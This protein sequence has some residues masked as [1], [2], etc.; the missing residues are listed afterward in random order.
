MD[1]RKFLKQYSLG[2][3]GGFFIPLFE[4]SFFQRGALSEEVNYKGKVLI[5]GAGVAGLYAGYILKSKGIDF[6]I[7]E[8][9]PQYGGRLAKLTGFANFPVDL[10]AQ[11]LHGKNNLIG[12]LIR[13][14]KTKVTL[15]QGKATYW[16]NNQLV[17][18]LP[19][20]IDIFEG[21]NLPDISFAEHALQEGLGDEYRY[22]VENIA[23]D[24]GA[25]SSR[26]SV[27]HTNFEFENWTSGEK[28]FRFQETFFDLIEKQIAY[29]IKDR[30]KHNTVVTQIDYTHKDILVLDADNN[31]YSAQKVIVTVPINILKSKDI[32]FTP[33]L[34]SE[35]TVAFSKIGMDAGMK[36]FFRF[37]HK[38]YDK[39]ISGGQ[40]C[41]AYVDD[42]LGK[43]PKDNVL[44][45]FVMG[46][47]AEYLTSLGSD[48]AITA[49]LLQEL[50]LM[51]RGQATASFLDSYVQNWTTNPFV[52][53]AYSY[54]TIGM[55]NARE[56]AA[57]SIDNRI[58]FA[59]EA[60]NTNGHHQ[61]VHG[62]SE[63]GYREVMKILNDLKNGF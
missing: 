46:K 29:P 39:Y 58:Y 20:N 33:Q 45:A 2:S 22:I 57:R 17:S 16:F 43:K 44:F 37:S 35:K 31:Q 4:P 63:T 14:S 30:I 5:I 6:E 52:K 13:K 25:D 41:A 24:Y 38:F 27:F 55:G 10:G 54:S 42:S 7:L 23:G 32:K 8:A 62:A 61:S 53:G 18:R 40:L 19:M 59:G 15:D 56:I 21:D 47:Q 48:E 49:A 51:Y 12:Q 34:P 3:L 28:D 26:I 50:D 36:V 60:M 1:R 11:W 9:S